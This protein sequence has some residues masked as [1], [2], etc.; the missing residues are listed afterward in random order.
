MGERDINDIHRAEGLD[1]ARAHHDSAKPFNAGEARQRGKPNGAGKDAGPP[2]PQQ[3]DPGPS[4]IG[5]PAYPAPRFRTLRE[6][7]AEYKPVAEV[8]GG[9][10]LQSGGLYTLT[11][12]PGPAR[13]HGW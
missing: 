7:C 12:K 10:V 1:A 4:P 6:F 3:G 11:A 8:V 9:G 13:P 5:E 2:N